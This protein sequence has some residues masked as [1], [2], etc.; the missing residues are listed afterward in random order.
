MTCFGFLRKSRKRP[1]KIR[2]IRRGS[3]LR[4]R[5]F[6]LLRSARLSDS[7]SGKRRAQATRPTADGYQLRIRRKRLG[8]KCVLHGRMISVP[9]ASMIVRRQIPHRAAEG[10][11]PYDEN[12]P[13]RVHANARNDSDLF[14]QR[15]VR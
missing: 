13:R 7:V 3:I 15:H 14:F 10:V 2:R 6:L 1:N 4:I 8:T 9:T 5:L 12:P 11:G